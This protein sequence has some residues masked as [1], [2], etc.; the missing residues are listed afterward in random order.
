MSVLTFI[1]IHPHIDLIQFYY[2]YPTFISI[3]TITVASSSSMSL[4]SSPVLWLSIVGPLSS[5]QFN[6]RLYWVALQEILSSHNTPKTRRGQERVCVCLYV[7]VGV[8]WCKTLGVFVCVYCV[9]TLAIANKEAIVYVRLTTR[10]THCMLVED[11]LATFSLSLI[12]IVVDIMS[13]VS[14]GTL[15]LS[16][17]SCRWA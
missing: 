14:V 15:L 6:G 1:H 7:Y 13:G 5:K 12:P 4:S 11:I 3:V 9:V 2:S 17:A 8:W 16:A 10:R